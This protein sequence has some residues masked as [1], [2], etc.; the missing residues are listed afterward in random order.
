MRPCSVWK[1][2][3]ASAWSR[4]D[5][6]GADSG[7]GRKPRPASPSEDR[8]GGALERRMPGDQQ[9][10]AVLARHVRVRR[11]RHVLGQLSGGL[12]RLR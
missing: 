6:G 5:A 3:R 11:H 12:Q 10:R 4:L 9:D 7:Q 2:S 8:G 1:R